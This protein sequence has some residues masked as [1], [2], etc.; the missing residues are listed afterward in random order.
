MASAK[1]PTKIR[2]T[3][4][5]IKPLQAFNFLRGLF[6]KNLIAKKTA[7][8]CHI[9]GHQRRNSAK[10]VG[11]LPASSIK[12]CVMGIHVTDNTIDCSKSFISV[13]FDLFIISFLLLFLMKV[14]F[15]VHHTHSNNA[16]T[17]ASTVST[18]A[19]I[20]LKARNM[21]SCYFNPH[22][23]SVISVVKSPQRAHPI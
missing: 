8:I 1:N 11:I 14:H 12:T 22:G 4:D 5:K 3:T 2:N 19:N 18:T 6:L 13:F 17:K 21:C 16:T 23:W 15:Q 20:E 7:D 10:P 9:T